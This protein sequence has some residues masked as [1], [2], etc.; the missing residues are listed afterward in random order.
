MFTSYPQVCFRRISRELGTNFA[1]VLDHQVSLKWPLQLMSGLKLD[2]RVS[3]WSTESAASN[4][5]WESLHWNV[6]WHWYST[7]K[8]YRFC[9]YPDVTIKA[10]KAFLQLC[11]TLG[12]N[13]VKWCKKGSSGPSSLCL[14]E[15]TNLT[16]SITLYFN[17]TESRETNMWQ[18]VIVSLKPYRGRWTSQNDKHSV[19]SWRQQNFVRFFYLKPI[20]QTQYFFE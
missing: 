2:T 10:Q 6:I 15:S 3:T 9:L 13:L 14:I 8:K 11:H 19:R 7:S 1:D 20:A 4:W 16:W 12:K 17:W 5:M 18:K